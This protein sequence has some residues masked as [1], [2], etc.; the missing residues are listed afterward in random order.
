M[1]YWHSLQPGPYDPARGYYMDNPT[2]ALTQQYFDDHGIGVVMV[3]EMYVP[4]GIPP[5][6]SAARNNAL[7]L[8]GSFGGWDIYTVR[9]PVSIATRGDALPESVSV[10]NHELH[11]SFAGGSGDVV[12]RQ[13]WFPRWQAEVNGEQVDIQRDETGYMRIAVPDGAVDVV[14]TYSVTGVDWLSRAAST[15]GVLGT[16]VFAWRGGAWRFVGNEEGAN[17]RH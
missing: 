11:A 17:G 4:S 14:L 8:Q 15:L 9:E 10:G 3:S 13:N 1:W 6:Q 2:E 12:I 7:E 16:V 5:R